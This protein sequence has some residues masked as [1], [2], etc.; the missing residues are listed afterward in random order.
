MGKIE[1]HGGKELSGII[2]VSGAKNAALPLMT[3][4]ILSEEP[5]NFSR[6]PDLRDVHSLI[7]LLVDLG[8]SADYNAQ[9]KK[10]TLCAKEITNQVA[11]YELVSKMRASVLVLGPLLARCGEA[12]VSMPGGCAIGARPVDIHLKGLEALGAT[13]ELDGGYVIAKAPEGGL[14]GGKF[15]MSFP[16]VGATEN[17]MMAAVL[18]KGTTTLTNVAREPEIVDLGECLISMGAEIE[19]LGTD[20]LIIKGK[21]S[22]HGADHEVIADRIEAGTF[23]FASAMTGG[24]VKVKG[25]NINHIDAVVPILS[26]AGVD[27]VQEGDLISVINRHKSL[28]GVD[29]ITEPYPGFPTDLQA[30]LMSMLTIADGA[31]LI[32]ETVFE[33][34]F[35]HVPELIRMGANITVHGS[36]ALIRG[37][38][39][40]KGADVM[41]TDL[42]ASASLVM[43][44]LIAKGKTTVHEIQHLERG[45]EDIVVKLSQIGADLRKID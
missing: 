38:K 42:R 9:T 44:G 26:K 33:N 8:L 20:T 19:G 22:L 5:I 15:H 6:I 17:V 25:A 30:Q 3:A 4:A 32:T 45:Y 37:V 36:S 34:R 13:I 16:S 41:A 24:N 31:A 43:A 21:E 11:S 40:L 10:L 18:A 14:K 29:V 12:K 28:R 27:L 39:H 1:I 35:M 2:E 7:D 23:I